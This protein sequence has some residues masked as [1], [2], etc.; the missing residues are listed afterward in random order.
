M[1]PDL[2][3]VTVFAFVTLEF[4][5]FFA[6]CKS[7]WLFIPIDEIFYI[8]KCIE[9]I[10]GFASLFSFYYVNISKEGFEET[11]YRILLIHHTLVK[12]ILSKI[13]LNYSRETIG[14]V[15]LCVLFM[16]YFHQLALWYYLGVRFTSLEWYLLLFSMFYDVFVDIW[17]SWL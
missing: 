16:V 2:K 13:V 5:L 3:T 10:L 14:N 15:L 12:L 7:L 17:E 9:S 6:S 1:L 4:V 8:G 11:D